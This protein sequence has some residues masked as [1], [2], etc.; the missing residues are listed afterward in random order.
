MG[1]V[2]KFPHHGRASAGVS[3]TGERAAN[4]TSKSAVTPASCAFG[5]ANTADHHSSG[6]RLRCSHLRTLAGGAPISSAIL[7]GES[8][9]PTIALKDVSASVMPTCLGQTVLKSKAEMS[10]DARAGKIY[11][12]RAM[13]RMSETEEKLAFIRRVKMARLAR[14][15]EGQRPILT[16]LELEQ[17]TYK[18]YETRTPLPWRFIPKFCAATGVSLEWLLTGEGKGPEAAE[19]TP[20]AEKR[21]RAIK[22]GR[23]A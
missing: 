14:F 23:A 7:P 5:V 11:E 2:L 1:R 18:Q 16:I 21:S 20:K 8:Q 3:R 17:G 4:S 9:S 10:H 13:D 22:R 12:T 15:P 19:V 6:I